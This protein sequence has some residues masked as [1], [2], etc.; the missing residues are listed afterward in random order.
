M[1]HLVRSRRALAAT[2]FAG[3]FLCAA[4]AFAQE[5]MPSQLGVVITAPQPQYHTYIGTLD[6]TTMADGTVAGT[7]QPDYAAPGPFGAQSV[8]V[9]GTIQGDEV[10]LNIGGA[11]QVTAH[12]TADGRL[13]GTAVV[14]GQTLAFDAGLSQS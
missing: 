12:Y 5:S 7:Y 3:A 9:N 4:P 10:S 6:L 2:I 11:W 1:N 13:H 14:E 8:A